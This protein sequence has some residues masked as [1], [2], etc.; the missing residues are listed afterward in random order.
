MDGVGLLGNGHLGGDAEVCACGGDVGDSPRM[1][2]FWACPIAQAVVG[3]LS[4]VGG[5]AVSR[6]A[7]WLAV[8]PGG[9]QQGV[10]DVVCLAALTAIERGRR[11]AR[12]RVRAHGPAATLVQRACACAVADLWGRLSGF[13]SLQRV[14]KRGWA[15]VPPEHPFVGLI[16]GRRLVLNQP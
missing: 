9:L 15:S 5:V 10:W 16:D 1:H 14:P 4:E 12:T 13:V 7:L 3:A 11:Y 2:H 8:C 6:D